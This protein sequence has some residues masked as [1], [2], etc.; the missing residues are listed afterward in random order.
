MIIQHGH[1]QTHLVPLTPDGQVVDVHL[2][3]VVILYS[4]DKSISFDFVQ[5]NLTVCRL[6]DFVCI[7][8]K[9]KKSIC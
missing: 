8:H 1:V 6:H 5:F 3:P 9:Y 2:V 7:D 4:I